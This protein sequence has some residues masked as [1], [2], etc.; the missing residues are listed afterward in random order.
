MNLIPAFLAFV[1]L[2]AWLVAN[3]PNRLGVIRAE[4]RV[5]TRPPGLAC[6]LSASYYTTSLMMSV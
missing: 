4:P 1:H 5:A 3:A 6:L 2:K